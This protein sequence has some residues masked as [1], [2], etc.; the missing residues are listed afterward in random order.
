[1]P[2]F[3]Y[4]KEMVDII[5]DDEFVT[6][7]DGGFRGFLVK[8]HG[9]PNSDATWIQDDD[10]RLLDPS[11]SDCYLSSHSS[12]SS[13]FQLGGMM[14]HGVYPYLGLNEIRSPSPMM[15]F[16]IISYLFNCTF[17]IYLFSYLIVFFG[18]IC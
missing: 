3:Q 5:L 7:R 14:G 18:F 1:M 13:S 17:W 15:I 8:W 10:L 4:S 12:K 2:S 16:I 11:L 9:R 6:S